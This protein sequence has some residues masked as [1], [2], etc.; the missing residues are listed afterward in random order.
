MKPL[1]I[2]HQAYQNFVFEQLQ[3]HYS[4]GLLT[5]VSNDYPTISKLWITDLSFVT[6]W[7]FETY[8]LK[9]SIPR[10]P[11]SMMCFYLLLF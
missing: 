4:G 1:S 3:K 6:T 5:L 7:L 2:N 8:P 9:G 11:D 10:D